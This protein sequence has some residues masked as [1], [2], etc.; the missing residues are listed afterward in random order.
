MYVFMIL[1][2]TWKCIINSAQI[3]LVFFGIKIAIRFKP[4]LYMYNSMCNLA[5]LYSIGRWTFPY[6]WPHIP[7]PHI[8]EHYWPTPIAVFLYVTPSQNGMLALVNVS[9]KASCTMSCWS[10]LLKKH[11]L[12]L[13]LLVALYICTSKMQMFKNIIFILGTFIKILWLVGLE[14]AFFTHLKNILI[15]PNFLTKKLLP[16]L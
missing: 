10:K 8:G 16:V 6:E 2:S 12:L 15:Q 11:V 4:N 14:S 9:N 5:A 7:S 3:L 13:L 1:F